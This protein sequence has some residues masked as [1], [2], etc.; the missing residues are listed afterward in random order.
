MAWISMATPVGAVAAGAIGT[1]G[2]IGS[3]AAGLEPALFTA[4]QQRSGSHAEL[5]GRQGQA[6][7]F[8]ALLLGHPLQDFRQ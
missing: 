8:A 7:R 4:E 3:V 5:Q 2:A 6:L 1:G